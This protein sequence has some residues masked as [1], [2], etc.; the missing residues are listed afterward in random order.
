[1][2][3]RWAYAMP[4]CVLF[5]SSTSGIVFNPSAVAITNHSQPAKGVNPYFKFQ[6]YVKKTE[7]RY[8]FYRMG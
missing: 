5:V 1:M 8:T 7:S 4:M 6:L 2:K 3:A